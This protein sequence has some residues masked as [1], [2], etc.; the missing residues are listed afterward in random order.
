MSAGGGVLGGRRAWVVLAAAALLALAA[1]AYVLRA[2]GRG[3]AATARP[4]AIRL[5][6]RGRL[7]FRNAGSNGVLASV[8][9]A[10]PGG[11]RLL[12]GLN[13]VRVHA[14]AG[15]GVCLTVRR[16]A[17]PKIFAVI[18]DR[19]L[20]EVR[21]IQ[22]P[23]APSRA[24]VSPSGR[25]VSWTVFVSGDSYTSPDLSTR[26]GILDMRTG[27][28]IASLEDFTLLKDGK[29]Y[30]SPDVN[31]WGVTFAADDHHFYATVRTKGRTYLV[32]G[33]VAART[34]RTLRENV[35]C[36]SL[37]P[38]GTR[39]VFKKATGDPSRPWR[40]H[41]LE[42]RTMGEIAL[43]ETRSV[44]DQAVWL[45][46]HAVLYGRLDGGT[47]DVWTVPADGTGAPRLLL[48]NAFSPAVVR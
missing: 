10:H 31:Y 5:D 26:T 1:T 47:T 9:L 7:L 39:L 32:Q 30:R 48:R 28:V 29:P 36:P 6:D 18:L 44:D 40:L 16:A 8:P 46:D 38:D 12:S 45:D 23:G 43:A 20:H 21:R 15:T 35:E 24:R 37:S 34:M 13:C 3:G 17:V 33:D 25:M 22:L 42:L 11:S 19:G 2:A 41:L 27:R 14:S 4:A